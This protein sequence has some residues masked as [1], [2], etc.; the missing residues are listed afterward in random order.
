M[1]TVIAVKATRK[2]C[3]LSDKPYSHIDDAKYH[4][5]MVADAY[6]KMAGNDMVLSGVSFQVIIGDISNVEIGSVPQEQII[7]QIYGC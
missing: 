1:F 5:D 6:K 4:A 2:P 7:Y 3:V